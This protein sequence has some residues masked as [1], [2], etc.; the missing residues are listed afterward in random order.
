VEL[1]SVDEDLPPEIAVDM[2]RAIFEVRLLFLQKS[3]IYVSRNQL[4][5]TASTRDSF[6]VSNRPCFIEFTRSS[7]AAYTWTLTV[8]PQLSPG[9]EGGWRFEHLPGGC[10]PFS[11]PPCARQR[12]PLCFQSR[13][14]SAKSATNCA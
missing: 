1:P 7:I 5:L 14:A 9:N 6:S 10:A 8:Y 12:Q 4:L 3:N 13:E 2:P 11:G